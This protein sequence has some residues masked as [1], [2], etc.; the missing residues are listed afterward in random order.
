MKELRHLQKKRKALNGVYFMNTIWYKACY[1]SKF[2]KLKKTGHRLNLS[3]NKEVNPSMSKLRG[4]YYIIEDILSELSLG[5]A[6]KARLQSLGQ[7]TRGNDIKR[8]KSF[9]TRHSLKSYHGVTATNLL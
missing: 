3:Y 9:C 8:G 6:I 7:L 2:E 4:T 1:S 5:K